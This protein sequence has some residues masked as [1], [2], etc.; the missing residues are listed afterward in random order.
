[1]YIKV[2]RWLLWTN[3][4]VSKVL[5]IYCSLYKRME[6]LY[7]RRLCRADSE[8]PTDS[9]L[10][11]FHPRQ[12]ITTSSSPE[13]ITS[14]PDN[15]HSNNSKQ[16]L[17]KCPLLPSSQSN[18]PKRTNRVTLHRSTSHSSPIPGWTPAS[19]VPSVQS[20]IRSL[21]NPL[22]RTVRSPRLRAGRARVFAA[23]VTRKRRVPLA[24]GVNAI[25]SWE[26][27]KNNCKSNCSAA[28]RGFPPAAP[29]FGPEPGS[30]AQTAAAN[31]Q[32]N[33]FDRAASSSDREP[34]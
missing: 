5:G 9:P 4:P 23:N 14:S 32:I 34:S 19:P 15:I 26:F 27:I 30:A 8:T 18:Q 16:R 33:C 21:P 3:S 6:T 22:P 2:E 11:H 24:A 17:Q 12:S 25:N 1:M 7:F 20:E 29:L 10:R 13:L 31:L 28:R